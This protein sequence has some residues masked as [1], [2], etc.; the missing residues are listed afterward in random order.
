MPYPYSIPAQS[1]AQQLFSIKQ[2][3]SRSITLCLTTSALDLFLCIGGK[4]ST[5]RQLI[6][7]PS[8]PPTHPTPTPVPAT[9][10]PH[11]TEADHAP[12]PLILSRLHTLVLRPVLQAG[13]ACLCHFTRGALERRGLRSQRLFVADL[14]ERL[15]REEV[16]IALGEVRA[17]DEQER[18]HVAPG[19]NLSDARAASAGLLCGCP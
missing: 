13:R 8:P 3:I 1:P 16:V 12:L 4:S 9:H 19:G 10:V 18:A 17:R 15:Y 2:Q 14:L 11:A 5:L 7:P 6:T